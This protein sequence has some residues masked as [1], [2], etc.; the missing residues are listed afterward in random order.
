MRENALILKDGFIL[1]AHSVD[2]LR[3]PTTSTEGR[4][5]KWRFF[6]C[7]MRAA[8]ILAALGRALPM[9]ESCPIADR[10]V[11]HRKRTDLV[12]MPGGKRRLEVLLVGKIPVT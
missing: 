12:L 7:S 2:Q 6:R 4:E 11:P 1:S 5:G 8:S 9:Y 10:K 3:M